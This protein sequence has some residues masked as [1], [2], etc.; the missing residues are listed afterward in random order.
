MKVRYGLGAQS[1]AK[2]DKVARAIFRTATFIFKC[3][4]PFEPC[5]K[6]FLDINIKAVQRP[7]DLSAPE[8]KL[9]FHPVSSIGE[10]YSSNLSI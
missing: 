6:Q 9:Q 5:F 4:L 8:G 7:F 1:F 3:T 10:F 2:S